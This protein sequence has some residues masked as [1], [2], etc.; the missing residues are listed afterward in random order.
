MLDHHLFIAWQ[1]PYEAG[2]EWDH[3]KINVT[4]CE[5]VVN[6][7]FFNCYF[8]SRQLKRNLLPSLRPYSKTKKPIKLKLGI[9]GQGLIDV[10]AKRNL[11]ELEGN[12]ELFDFGSCNF[13]EALYKFTFLGLKGTFI[14]EAFYCLNKSLWIEPAVW[15]IHSTQIFL[16]TNILFLTSNPNAALTVSFIASNVGII[17][18][19]SFL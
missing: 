10:T 13:R 4:L 19:L 2:H 14:P 12:L 9:C 6:V 18:F 7:F 1:P 16:L 17:L 15:L 11:L 8:L 5:W 3:F